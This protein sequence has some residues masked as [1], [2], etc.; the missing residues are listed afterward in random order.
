MDDGD[1]DNPIEEGTVT[2]ETDVGTVV[3]V[4]VGG[5]GG[6]SIVILVLGDATL[7]Y[8]HIVIE[9]HMRMIFSL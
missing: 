3:A 8:H 1:P 9:G 5:V 4:A 7:C 2:T 6:V